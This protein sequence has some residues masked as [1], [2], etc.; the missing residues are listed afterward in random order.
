MLWF[1]QPLKKKHWPLCHISYPS[2]NVLLLWDLEIGMGIL[3]LVLGATKK[4]C[5]GEGCNYMVIFLDF[6]NHWSKTLERLPCFQ[7]NCFQRGP[8]FMAEF[9]T[10][11]Y[12]SSWIYMF[13]YLWPILGERG[14]FLWIQVHCMFLLVYPNWTPIY[15]YPLHAFFY[16]SVSLDLGSLWA[17]HCT[18]LLAAGGTWIWL[19]INFLNQGRWWYFTESQVSIST[20]LFETLKTEN[21]LPLVS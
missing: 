2:R 8:M 5:P 13:L 10:T 15:T 4:N 11:C 16:R 17:K 14:E 1:W 19:A 12:R 3:F 20:V 18:Y 6:G 7:C 9:T 21:T